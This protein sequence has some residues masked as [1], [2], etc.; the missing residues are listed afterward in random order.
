MPLLAKLPNNS[1]IL[2][3]NYK[4]EPQ[5]TCPNCNSDFLF[6][7]GQ[8]VIK[9]F[10]HKVECIYKTEPE[11]QEHL[12]MK[13]K[14]LDL[15]LGSEPEKRLNTNIADVYHEDKDIRRAF[16]CQCSPISPQEIKQRTLKY[17]RQG[18]SV[19]WILGQNNYIKTDPLLDYPCDD[20]M[21]VYCGEIKL[22]QAEKYLKTLYN[23][24]LHY[25]DSISKTF[26]SVETLRQATRYNEFTG[27]RRWLKTTFNCIV[28]PTNPIIL[29]MKNY[30]Y[31][32][33]YFDDI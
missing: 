33:S 32:L 19:F 14:L 27:G 24:K 21:A 5:P 31:A 10:R 7:N 17:T 12:S 22:T 4:G 11:T 2:A 26:F 15:L 13:Q 6:V 30:G 29:D 3:Q 16:E 28:R 23:G 8:K 1:R 18:I 20:P 25:Y 9:H